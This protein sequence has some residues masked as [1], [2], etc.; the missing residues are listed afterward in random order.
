M[1]QISEPNEVRMEQALFSPPLSKQRVDFAIGLI[2]STSA[3]SL[4]YQ[5]A[6]FFPPPPPF[7]L[8]SVDFEWA[9]RL[10]SAA[11]RVASL[12]PCWSVERPWRRLSAWMS[13]QEASAGQ[14]RSTLAPI[15]SEAGKNHLFIYL[16]IPAAMRNMTSLLTRQILHAKLAKKE[17]EDSAAGSSVR[18]A[19]LYGGSIT[20]YDSRLHGFDVGTCLEV[21]WSP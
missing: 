4:V 9:S 6:P 5:P 2:N 15:I 21:R 20:D 19:V 11:G 8:H 16:L 13:P 3:T 18:S 12:T 7:F 14:R 17:E 1:L 10:T